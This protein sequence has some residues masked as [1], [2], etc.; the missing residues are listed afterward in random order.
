MNERVPPDDVASARIRR[1]CLLM[2]NRLPETVP[3]AELA[4][5]ASFS[6]RNFQ[7]L[8]KKVVG[9]SVREHQLRL[10]LEM[11]AWCLRNSDLPVGKVGEEMRFETHSG[12]TRAFQRHFQ[13]SPVAWREGSANVALRSANG[14]AISREQLSACSLSPVIA[15]SPEIRLAAMRYTG[16]T[17]GILSVWQH[18]R[19]FVIEHKLQEPQMQ[20]IGLHHDTWEADESQYRYDACVT[21]PDSFTPPSDQVVERVIPAGPIA[22]ARVAGS[23]LNVEAAWD[24]FLNVWFP[25]SGVTLR[26]NYGFDLYPAELILENRLQQVFRAFT[27]FDVSICL[28]VE[29]CDSP[30]SI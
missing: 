17:L 27:K 15:E 18:M 11:A 19:R 1:A 8:F 29:A 20:F 6:V 10:R 30:P 25:A 3:V 28:P 24:Q 22:F 7:K 21:I 12:F 16:P 5:A 26:A 13:M 9:E 2:E 23:I 4:S 14:D